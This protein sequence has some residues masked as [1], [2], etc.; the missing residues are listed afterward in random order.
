MSWLIG[1]YLNQGTCIK[2]QVNCLL[3]YIANH[4]KATMI[5]Y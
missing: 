4:W 5:S 2:V 3:L 1:T